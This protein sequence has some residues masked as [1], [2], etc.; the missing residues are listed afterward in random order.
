MIATS[1]AGDPL[2]DERKFVSGV[3]RRELSEKSL[4]ERGSRYLK[5]RDGSPRSREGRYAREGKR[6]NTTLFRGK[7]E[8][9]HTR[10]GV[11]LNHHA[12]EPRR[13]RRG[14]LVSSRDLFH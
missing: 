1:E 2:V 3:G 6:E 12:M 7:K 11:V 10:P 9:S 4:S 8:S 14:S 13:K 5:R